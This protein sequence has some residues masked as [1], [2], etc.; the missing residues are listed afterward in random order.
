MSSLLHLL[1]V[2]YL[3]LS[4]FFTSAES[5]TPNGLGVNY[6]T[7]GNNLPS[8]SQSVRLIRTLNAGSVKIYD[9]NASILSALAGTG[10]RVSVMV[11]NQIIP[12]IAGNQSA[13]DAWVC[14]NVVKY[15]Y[16]KTRIRYLLVGNE[17]LSDYSIQNSTWLA[18][19]PAMENLHKS[20]RSK[21]IHKIKIGTPLAMD[22]LSSSF[23]PSNGTFRKDIS[24][25]VLFPLL[26]F[27][28]KTNSFF[29][30]DAY[31]YFAWSQNWQT[32]SLNYALFQADPKSYYQDPVSGL[33]YKNLLDQMLDSVIFAMRKLGFW[34]VKLAVAETGWPNKGDIDQIGANVYN[35]AIYNRNL[36]KKFMQNLGTPAR[37]GVP[38]HVFVFSLYNE[39]Q[40]PGPGTERHWGMYFPN[41]KPV[42][43]VDLSAKRP[44]DS[45]PPLP[46]PTNNTPYKGP[47]WCVTKRGRV[48]E[49]LIQNAV[50][51][52]CEQASNIC[53]A[54]QKGGKCF[55]PNSLKAHANW[56]FN[57]Y[58]QQFR[59]IGGT[60]SF[61]GLAVLTTKDPS[62]G[63][64]KFPS[65]LS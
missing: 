23:P 54:V 57:S 20:L 61:N 30:V 12:A 47:L 25:S 14:E 5:K 13:A 27:L 60:C 45:Y 41:K 34:D 29:F 50:S 22:A 18:L 44:L 46:V 48:N 19:V 10:L 65:S 3:L 63:S 7:L 62:Y 15:Y 40:K 43:E 17:I 9:A 36:A 28:R 31:P 35:A 39:N 38:M 8:P 42:Y 16:G 53:K 2:F 52:A 1:S 24:S 4:T 32:I 6:G 55:E 49:T 64:C 58:W 33:M 56:A 11:P 21:N 59:K 51:Y 37:P 26:T